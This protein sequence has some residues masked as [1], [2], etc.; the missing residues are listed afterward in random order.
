ML[1]RILKVI[2]LITISFFLFIKF[3]GN[4]KDNIKM[5]SIVVNDI[6]QLNPINVNKEIQPRTIEEVQAAIKNS[7]GP[8]SIG[9][10]RYSMGGQVALRNSLHLDM[11]AFNKILNFSKNNKEITVQSGVRWRD[12][13]DYVDPY[14]LSVKI[15]QTYSN[16][17]VG[18]SLGVNV[19][20]RYMGEGPLIMSVKSIKIVLS[21]GR[22]IEASPEKQ[23]DIFYSAI[24]GYGGIGVVVEATLLLADNS[25][26]ERRI[27]KMNASDFPK[28]FENKVK[29]NH[30]LVFFN[31]D[32]YPPNFERIASVEWEKTNKDLTIKER[33]IPRD[34][35][36]F[37]LPKLSKVISEMPFGYQLREYI[38]EPLYYMED[39]VV[40]RN[41]EASYDVKEL[42]PGDRS[43]VTYVLQ[44][45]FLPVERFLEFIPKMRKIFLDN[46]VN[47]L[48]VSI[49]HAYKDPGSILAW[50]KSESFAFVVYYKQGTSDEDKESV[51]KWTREM[52]DAV[53]N[54]G[55]RYYLPYQILATKEQFMK[56]YPEADEY[57]KIKKKYDPANRFQNQLLNTYYPTTERLVLDETLKINDYKKGEDQTYLTVPEWYLVF[58][59]KEYVD[60]LKAGNNPSDFPFIKSIDEY[61]VLYDRVNFLTSEKYQKNDEYQTMLKIIGISTTAEYLTKSIW[62]NTF[63]RISSWT[64]TNLNSPEEKIITNAFNDYVNYIYLEPW[65][66]FSF[67]PWIKSI[68]SQ[69]FFGSNFIRRTERKIFFTFEF[70]IKEVYA[71]VLKMGA[72]SAYGPA[73]ER[74]V[75]WVN[76]NIDFALIDSRIKILK[77]LNEGNSLISMP[78]WQPFTEIVPKLAS[79]GVVFKE[80]AGNDEIVLSVVVPKDY[81]E[82]FTESQVLFKSRMV[83]DDSKKRLVILVK[84]SNLTD[85]INDFDK[86]SIPM[87]HLYDF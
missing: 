62:E 72:A 12:I 36:Y 25:K 57:F 11:R 18:G 75:L 41:W 65:Y 13:Q 58:N 70:L 3:S 22:L 52:I 21:D 28:Y 40:W 68:W 34:R 74:I 56:A 23:S 78:R 59:P 76:G 69:P 63:G 53:I 77:K 44:E 14:N 67:Y 64:A 54:S 80:I 10:G 48:N 71:R 17:T 9:G 55:G 38:L 61:W 1:K 29:T 32:M 85:L 50:A 7:K 45:Y 35:E 2:A 26:I 83:S 39:R 73:N 5:H 37:W 43:K 6:T 24:G 86:K 27:T 42:D 20:G 33:L 4:P 79:H 47:V 31:G 46:N 15:M 84:L 49:R 19:H 81:I 8:I 66:K 60:Y 87:E 82:K 30:N 16:F 51:K